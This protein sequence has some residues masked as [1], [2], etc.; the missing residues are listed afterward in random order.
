LK[1]SAPQNL[2]SLLAISPTASTSEIKRAYRVLARRFH[3]DS[4]NAESSESLFQGVQEAYSI[5]TN[6]EKRRAYDERHGF[7]NEALDHYTDYQK[8]QAQAPDDSLRNEAQ[9]P[10][11]DGEHSEGLAAQRFSKDRSGRKDFRGRVTQPLRREKEKPR[12]FWEKISGGS[13]QESRSDPDAGPAAD[14]EDLRGERI[15]PFTIDALES[16]TGT[17]RE[18]AIQDEHGPRTLRIKIPPGVVDGALLRMNCPGRGNAPDRPVQA[19]VRIAPHPVVE[20]EGS[21]IVL[22]IP[23]TV[24]EAI[25]GAEFDVPALDGPVR[26]K[27]PPA[28]DIG[29]RLKIRERG[30]DLPPGPRSDI[31]VKFYIV[32]PTAANAAVDEASRAIEA[33]YL[34]PVRANVPKFL[35]HSEH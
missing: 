20:R 15:F 35:K 17:S 13:K 28:W 10:S 1:N 19:R 9:Q 31:Y 25:V 23:I 22:K 34:N 29:K 11:P 14:V 7:T 27:L 12:S 8:N 18:L 4:G 32:V 16:V 30:F 3:P 21:D 24:R 5:L 33:N 2:Y 26:V 6:P